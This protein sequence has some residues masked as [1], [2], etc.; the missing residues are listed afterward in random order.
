VKELRNLRR[1]SGLTQWD[2]AHAT[3]IDRSKIC[4]IETGRIQVKPEEERTIRRALESAMRARMGTIQTMLGSAGA[5]AG[6]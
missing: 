4:F 6:A 1:V 5:S 2:L 3:G